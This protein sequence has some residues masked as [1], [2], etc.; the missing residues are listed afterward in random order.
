MLTTEGLAWYADASSVRP[1]GELRFSKATTCTPLANGT[2][3]RVASGV[4]SG[5]E[6]SATEL[7][8]CATA[9]TLS[10]QGELSAGSDAERAAGLS[11]GGFAMIEGVRSKPYLNGLVAKLQAF[12]GASERW[13]VVVAKPLILGGEPGETLVLALKPQNLVVPRGSAGPRQHPSR[14]GGGAAGLPLEANIPLSSWESEIG[15][16]LSEVREKASADDAASTSGS[17]LWGE[18]TSDAAAAALAAVAQTR[19]A[20]GLGL[21]ARLAARAFVSG[22]GELRVTSDRT[23]F[24]ERYEASLLMLEALTPHQTEKLEEANRHQHVLLEA[25]AGGG[26]TFV[27]MARMLEI[28][29]RDDVDAARGGGCV[30]F[31]CWSA[32]LCLFV[33]RWICKRIPSAEARTRALSRLFLVFAP[34]DAGPRAVSLE[35]LSAFS[36]TATASP[37]T[38]SASTHQLRIVTTPR[39]PSTPVELLVVDESHHIYARPELRATVES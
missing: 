26:K 1:L 14:G 6:G 22:R 30:V 18:K 3:L 12:D 2:V 9:A 29:T 21:A 7:F 11:P 13:A 25:P 35:A 16:R 19:S 24:A 36:A 39:M 33:C 37:S 20:D 10:S 5:Q 34:M 28:L 15:D 23:A 31:A 27:A 4:T 17:T 8:L 38:S 32:P